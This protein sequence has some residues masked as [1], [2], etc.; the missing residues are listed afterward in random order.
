MSAAT[1][2]GSERA[3]NRRW[4]RE[5]M[6]PYFFIAMKDEPEAM[7]MLSRE[8]GELCRNRRLILADREKSLIMALVNRPGTLYETLRRVQEREI[9]YA[10]IAHSDDP[11]PGLEQVLEIQRFEFDRKSDAEIVANMGAVVPSRIRR[12]VAA[13]LRKYYPEFDLKDMDRI[14][15]IIWLNNENYVRISPPRRVAQVLRL[16]QEA[17]RRGGLYLDMEEMEST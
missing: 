17:N 6:N 15:R 16:Y 4:L 1:G 8:L 13:A 5:Q 11:I 10:M 12:Q 2:P 14:L 3:A 9:S 7:A